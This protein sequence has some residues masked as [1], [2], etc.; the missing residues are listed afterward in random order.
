MNL[1]RVRT[2]VAKEVSEALRDLAQLRDQVLAKRWNDDKYNQEVD[3]LKN[4]I[5]D[6]LKQAAGETVSNDDY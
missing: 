1:L 3:K 5:D 4:R 2:L 6:V